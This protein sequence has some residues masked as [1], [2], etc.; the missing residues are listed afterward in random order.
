VFHGDE[1]ARVGVVPPTFPMY[2]GQG[3]SW[4]DVS[5][6]PLFGETQAD[7]TPQGGGL[8]SPKA[9]LKKGTSGC[10]LLKGGLLGVP[11]NFFA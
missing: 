10:P 2:P 6:R 5:P 4:E 11:R 7:A 3:D 1:S 8:L 9:P